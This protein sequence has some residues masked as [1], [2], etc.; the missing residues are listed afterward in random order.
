MNFI[1]CQMRDTWQSVDQWLDQANYLRLALAC[2]S[3]VLTSEINVRG[4]LMNA[5]KTTLFR[6]QH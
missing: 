4:L 1:R 5:D 2:K 3:W 6:L